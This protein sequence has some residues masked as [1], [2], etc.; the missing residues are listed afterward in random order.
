MAAARGTAACAWVIALQLVSLVPEEESERDANEELEFDERYVTLK[1]MLV[2]YMERLNPSL[3]ASSSDTEGR[4]VDSLAAI[5]E[6]QTALLER[7]SERSSEAGGDVLSQLLAQQTQVLERVSVQS[8]ASREPHVKLPIIRLPTFSG[9]IEDWKRY[10]DTF[11]TLIHDSELSSVQKHQYLVGSLS[12]PAARIIESIEILE[13][14]YAIAW[15]LLK[16]RYEDERAI[17]KRHIQCLFEMPRVHRESSGAIQSLVDHVQKHLRILQSM[18]LPTESWGELIIFLIERNLDNVTR[19]SWEEHIEQQ[20]NIPTSVILDFLQRRCQVLERASLTGDSRD[21]VD[22]SRTDS[23]QDGKRQQPCSNLRNKTSLSTTAEA[24]GFSAGARGGSAAAEEKSSG[25]EASGTSSGGSVYHVAGELKRRQVLMSTA[26]V[27]GADGGNYQLRVLLDSASEINFVTLA[28]CRKLGVKLDDVHQNINGLNN[29]NCIIRHSCQLQVKSRVSEFE[30][31]LQCL[32]VPR[33]VG[34]LPPFTIEISKLAIPGNL[35]LADPIFYNPGRIDALIG[36]EFFLQLLQA[37][38]IELGENLPT[39]QNSK[40]GWVIAGSIPSHLIASRST[41]RPYSNAHTCLFVRQDSIYNELAR[42]WEL[43]EYEMKDNTRLSTEDQACEDYFVNTVTRNISGRFVVRLPFR[44]NKAQLGE[45]RQIAE[46]RLNYLERKF[47]RD[48]EFHAR[49][50][51]FMREYIRLNHMSQV[52]KDDDTKFAV[53]LPHHGVIRESSTTTKLRVVFDGSA[54]TASG[55]S[56]NDTLMVGAGWQDNI[57]DLL[58]RFRLHAIAITADLK[59][60]YRQVI[61][62]E[63]DRNYQ[64]ILW[65]F[66][67]SDSIQEYNLNTVTYGL[68]CAPFLAIRCVRQLAIDSSSQFGEASRVLLND[69]YVDDILTDVSCEFE[70]TRLIS[71]LKTLLNGSGFELHKWYSNCDEVMNELRPTDRV[72]ESSSIAINVDAVKTLG[73]NW[74]YRRDIFQFTVQ[75]IS[76][77]IKTKRQVL[78]TISQLFDPLGL[79][80]PILIRAKLIMQGTWSANLKWDDPLTGELQ[81]AW[82]EY[83]NDLR[84]IHSI[85]IPRRI[86]PGSATRLNMHAFCDASMKA[87]G[88]CIY[89]QTI[90]SNG[91]CNYRLVCSKSRVAPVKSK[92]VTLPKLELCGAVVLVRLIKNVKKA[93]GVELDNIYAWSDSTITLAWIS[94]DPSRQKVFVSNRVVEIQSLLSADHWRHV[95]SADNP[96]DLISRGTSLYDLKQCRLWWEGPEWLSRINEYS[97]DG[98]RLTTLSQIE[99]EIIRSEERSESRVFLNVDGLNRTVD[100]LINKCSSLSRVERIVA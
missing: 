72:R 26:I 48:P 36:S 75:P 67:S 80:S 93:L 58:L 18:K 45:S 82:R 95:K 98:A 33:I 41:N 14:N 47:Q 2:H 16:G 60:M 19:K 81:R 35:K 64:R 52:D 97:Q 54:K 70:A 46:K 56:L 94:G 63:Q 24:G 6:Q 89:L 50:S 30:L 51:E 85:K 49:Y 29:M 68:A 43:E 87:Y 74:H 90:D 5:L 73:L 7:L 12:G 92:T 9:N 22:K 96:A 77:S 62:H 3:P 83:V 91:H 99:S 79:I 55:V 66:S 10:S 57:I 88:A 28:A 40:L 27:R 44:G 23:K 8:G 86:V 15:E 42:F 11:K 13:Q 53:Y 71:Q 32:V 17:K 84:E 31:N 25:T 4:S 59:K 1:S 76:D 78:S 61:V 20:E 37:G 69:L 39:L 65:R 34:E 100:A 38:R 21:H